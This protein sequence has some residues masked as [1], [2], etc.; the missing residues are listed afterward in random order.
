[1]KPSVALILLFCFSVKRLISSALTC[2]WTL[3]KVFQLQNIGLQVLHDKCPPAPAC[4]NSKRVT[5]YRVYKCAQLDKNPST[6]WVR[7]PGVAVQCATFI[8]QRASVAYLA[9]F[10]GF[11][12]VFWGEIFRAAG[13]LSCS[14]GLSCCLTILGWP[15][16]G[17]S[18]KE[19]VLFFPIRV[20]TAL[21]ER[22]K[23]KWVSWPT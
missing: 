19:S 14:K 9:R 1:M 11:S 6:K 22:A 3:R 8:C 7:A 2:V 20:I 23:C 21:T 13:L 10:R 17:H 18:F 12:L 4:C 15:K 5:K 16:L